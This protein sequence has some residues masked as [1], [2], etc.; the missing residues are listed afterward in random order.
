MNITIK[1]T[2]AKHRGLQDNIIQEIRKRELYDTT[3]DPEDCI[4]DLELL[5]VDLRQL[6]TI[7]HDVEMM[8]HILSNLT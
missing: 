5:R 2:W 3:R 1:K 7:N 6:G 4:T 8:T